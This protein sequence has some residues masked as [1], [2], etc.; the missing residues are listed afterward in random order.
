MTSERGIENRD[1]SCF[2]N[3]TCF[4]IFIWFGSILFNNVVA[5][6][7]LPGLLLISVSTFGP[8]LRILLDMKIAG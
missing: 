1:H 2:L 7:L 5:M 6:Y 4:C 3:V 8:L